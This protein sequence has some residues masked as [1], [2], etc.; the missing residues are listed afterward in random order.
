[1]TVT[2]STAN[3]AFVAF[4]SI[5]DS[6][7]GHPVYGSFDNLTFGGTTPPPPTGGDNGGSGG[8]NGT[9]V[10]EPSSIMLLGTG[11]LGLVARRRR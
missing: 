10:P 2:S 7:N 5:S 11:L 3:I 9:S 8:D 4:S 6:A 1:L